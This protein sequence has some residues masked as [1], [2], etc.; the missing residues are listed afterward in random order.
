MVFVHASSH[1][2]GHKLVVCAWSFVLRLQ[3]IASKSLKYDYSGSCHVSQ[4]ADVS[5]AEQDLES[6]SKHCIAHGSLLSLRYVFSELP[7][8]AI[9]REDSHGCQKRFKN[10]LARILVLVARVAK[11]T[12]PV[13]ALYQDTY[14]GK[15]LPSLRAFSEE[16]LA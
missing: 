5:H 7:W 2:S 12:L 14:L 9:A 6:A 15:T 4:Q 11:V 16:K 8:A 13:L 3:Q 10:T 1:R